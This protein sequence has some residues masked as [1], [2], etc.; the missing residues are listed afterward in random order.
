MDEKKN[1]EN[2]SLDLKNNVPDGR[3]TETC[4]CPALLKNEVRSTS[5][6]VRTQG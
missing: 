2:S 3:F 4:E 5:F 6:E 1:H